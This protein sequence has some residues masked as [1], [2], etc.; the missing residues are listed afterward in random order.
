M[1]QTAKIA[2]L[3]AAFALSP[4]LSACGSD[5]SA[6]GSASPSASSASASE[7]C[8]PVSGTPTSKQYDK[9]GDV[10]PASQITFDTNCGPIVIK[11]DPDAPKTV[12]SMTFLAQEG[13]FDNTPCHR[14]TTMGIYVLQCGD[15]TGRGIGNP[16]YAIPNEN[17]PPGGF[18]KPNYPA[19]TVAM[20]NSG[21]DTNGSQFFIVYKD[22]VLPS[23]YTIWGKVVSGLD[24]VQRVADQGVS[25]GTGDG[26]P[27]QPV[28][29]L[30]A[31]AN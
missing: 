29:I 1:K 21:P 11:T 30:S 20:A 10:A 23:D 9:P 8:A 12:K 31:S 16:G 26:K 2:A 14:L 28:Q 19:G 15:P 22:T 4:L 25:N 24:I 6:D 5:T 3:A 17:L 7:T 18:Q 13:Y 27:V